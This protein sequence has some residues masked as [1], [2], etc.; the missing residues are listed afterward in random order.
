MK[1]KVAPPTQEEQLKKREEVEKWAKERLAD[2]NTL[3]VDVETTGLPSRDPKTEVVSIAMINNEGRVA[4][5][6]LVNPSRPIPLESQKIHG[7]DDRMVKDSPPFKILGNII[8]GLMEGKHIV[9]Y[10]A[11]FDVHLLVTLF[12]RYGIDIPDFEVSCAMEMYSAYVG[13]WTKSKEDYKWQ[14]LPKLAYGKAHDALVD[15]ESTRLLMMKMAGDH[16][17]DPSPND[18]DLTF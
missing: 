3:I 1:L 8:A 18:I 12:Q 7:I 4:L 16:S 10:N 13:D 9:C 15:C 11:N 2:H 5:A 6:G 14:K 17:A